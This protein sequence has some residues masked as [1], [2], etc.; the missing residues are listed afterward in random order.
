MF[1]WI[2]NNMLSS[3]DFTALV[4]TIGCPNTT[5]ASE[6]ECNWLDIEEWQTA[7]AAA[8][9]RGQMDYWAG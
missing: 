5:G 9:S 7:S 8:R 3:A 6:E 2:S 4:I 1:L